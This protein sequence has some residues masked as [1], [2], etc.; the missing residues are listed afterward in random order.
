VHAESFHGGVEIEVQRGHVEIRRQDRAFPWTEKFDSK[1]VRVSEF[2]IRILRAA[3][4]RT[5][6]LLPEIRSVFAARVACCRP[7]GWLFAGKSSSMPMKSVEHAHQKA[8]AHA[9]LSFVLYDF[10]HTCATRWAERGMGVETIT[11]LLGHANLRTVMRYVHLSQEH[12]DRS[13]VLYG[14]EPSKPER[15]PIRVQ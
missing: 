6:K 5:L 10:R 11:R 4:K 2:R 14:V 3:G 1:V 15:V 9:G 8:L 12:L 7:V 13:M